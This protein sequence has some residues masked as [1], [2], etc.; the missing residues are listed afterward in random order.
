MNN[1]YKVFKI[2]LSLL[3]IVVTGLFAFELMNLNV[4]PMKLFIPVVIIVILI[5][6]IILVILHFYGKGVISRV[7]TTCFTI[8]VCVAMAFGSFYLY[9][10]SNMF[11][12]VT[13]NEGDVKNTVSVIVK[14][15]SSIEDIK[16]LNDRTLGV[17]KTIDKTGTEKS[18]EDLQD[19]NVT[20][21]T[22]EYNSIQAEV[23]ALYSDEVPAIVLNESYR[24]SVTENEQYMSFNEDTKV[25]HETVFYTKKVSTTNKVDDITKHP[26]T[27]LISGSDSRNG[28]N[29]TGRSDV[30]MLATVNPVTNTVLITSIPRDYYVAT[31]CDPSYGCQQGALDKLTHTGLH[32]VETTKETI[33]S[34]LGIDINYT[35]RV[36]FSSVVNLVDAL[37]GIEV[38]VAPGYAVPS[39]YTN[40]SYGV[41]EGVNQLN[42]EAALAYARER[43]AY[44]EGDRQRVKN[45][46]EVLLAVI[47]KAISPTMITNYASFM[48]ALSGAFETDLTSE[49][50]QSLIQYQLNESPSWSFFQYSLDGTGSSE[51]CAELGD[52]ASVMIPDSNTVN[53]AKELI[54]L[55]E[56]GETITEEIIN[57]PF[58]T[59]TDTVSEETIE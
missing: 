9:R 8:V 21:E 12:K 6:A 15:D 45:Q 4:L 41:T 13:S 38:N 56:N 42:G 50:M 24:D 39:F 1:V 48:D 53:R 7:L 17:L 20:P 19:N 54:N 30:N 51:L 43:Y 32:G 2:V 37:G 59:T 57:A 27:V 46:Q 23:E 16:D 44:T 25:I 40:P 18:L 35:I 33:E 22:S 55:V 14:K 10:T 29:E 5:D 47:N 36:N 58:E 3:L 31:A 34:F 52:Y 26:F 28:F 49:E 11:N